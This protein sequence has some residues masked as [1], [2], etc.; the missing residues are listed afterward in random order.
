MKKTILVSALALLAIGAQAQKKTTTSATVNFD[1]TTPKDDLPKASNSTVIASLDTKSGA[2]AFEAQVKSFNFTNATIQEHFNAPNWLNSE[3]YPT[4]SFKGEIA[5]MGDINFSQDGDYKTQAKGTLN[6][7]G[8]S[9]EISTPALL[10]VKEGKI[11]A[12]ANFKVSLADYKISNS[13][14]GKVDDNPKISVSAVF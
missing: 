3:E 12:S 9:H 13:A 2:L 7:H 14:K 11:H 1:A 8:V 6:L 10:T 5:N 4:I